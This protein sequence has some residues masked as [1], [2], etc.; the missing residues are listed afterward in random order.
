MIN[1]TI[2][3]DS[4]ST[5]IFD[6]IIFHLNNIRLRFTKTSDVF[7][8]I[9]NNN[10][11][12]DS[13]SVSGTG[14]NLTQTKEVSTIIP[15][16]IRKHHVR[17]LLDAPCGDFFWMKNLLLNIDK[18]IGIDIVPEIIKNN[19]KQFQTNKHKFYVKDIIQDKLPKSDLI[20]CRDC[21]VHFS[22]RDIYK[23]IKNIKSSK[24]KY[25][26]TTTFTKHN[27]NPNI[28]TG[29]WRPINLQ[30]APFYFPRP[31]EIYNEKCTELNGEFD[32][33]SLALWKIA[34]LPNF[35]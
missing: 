1:Y 15:K 34:D 24:S 23:T 14:S 5:M 31:L 28:P 18:Y 32:D 10:L 22:T 26:L 6:D 12:N 20:L 8:E 16:V 9:Y 25:L 19:K 4:K 21:L 11:W 27:R 29:R 35:K 30:T 17:F 13:L 7:S 3:I 2:F 33:K